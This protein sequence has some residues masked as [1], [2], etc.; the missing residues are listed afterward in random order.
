MTRSASSAT[1]LVICDLRSTLTHG[2]PLHEIVQAMLPG[3]AGRHKQAQL[4]I[5]RLENN[6]ISLKEA[7][8]QITHLCRAGSLRRAVEYA[9]FKMKMVNGFD[10][11]VESLHRAEIG[12]VIISPVFSVIT[13]TLRNIYGHD[14][15]LE[16]V[17]NPLQFALDGDPQVAV[18]ASKLNGMIERFFVKARDHKA[19]DRMQATGLAA[20]DIEDESRKAELVGKIA[21]RHKVP[22]EK[23]AYLASRSQEIDALVQVV[24]HGGKAIAFNY[25][26][27]LVQQVEDSSAIDADQ[28]HWTDARSRRANL[29]R[30]AALI[31]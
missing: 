14:R 18:S 27:G 8:E 21:S 24:S 25:H 30:P 26:H 12:L 6:E 1:A 13:E 10:Q 28:I 11:F 29:K 9:T 7:L 15:F 17:A 2:D 23:V 20:L 4:V 22:L 19:F 16:I 5:E 3:D 31:L